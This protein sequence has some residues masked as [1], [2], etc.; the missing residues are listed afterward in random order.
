MIS[1]TAHTILR[2]AASSFSFSSPG[3]HAPGARMNASASAPSEFARRV[4]GHN[5]AVLEALPPHVAEGVLQIC[6]PAQPQDLATAVLGFAVVLAVGCSVC[7]LCNSAR[8]G[9]PAERRP[10][11]LR[12]ILG[13][14]AESVVPVCCSTAFT[15]W[16]FDRVFTLRWGVGPPIVPLSPWH[17]LLDVASWLLNFEVF[18]YWT[19]RLLH[20]ERICG[21][22]VPI[23]KW[24]HQPHHHYTRPTAFCAQAI[25]GLEGVYFAAT[26]VLVSLVYPTSS[27][28]QFGLGSFMLTWSI[29]AHDSDGRLD[30]GFHYEHHNHPDT[31]FGFL[32]FMDVLCG[33]MW[34]GEK[35]DCRGTGVLPTY[36]QHYLGRLHNF[37]HSGGSATKGGTHKKRS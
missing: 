11:R 14:L 35:F 12:Q 13:E 15:L 7:E 36:R 30:G 34:L 17:A 33:T 6:R 2:L 16:W 26:S 25:T 1:H 32:G 29:A 28:V 21:V 5:A 4:E 37:L 22:R 20:V 31:N 23:Y 3:G 10:A 8:R 24:V 9:Q 27:L 18:G 19:H